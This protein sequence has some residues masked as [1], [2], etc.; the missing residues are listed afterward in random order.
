MAR[1]GSSSLTAY[2]PDDD[3]ELKEASTSKHSAQA[4]QDND[5]DDS[6]EGTRLLS[7]SADTTDRESLPRR[8]KRRRRMPRPM[9]DESLSTKA[10]SSAK[11][12]IAF[13]A[14]SALVFL[15]IPAFMPSSSHLYDGGKSGGGR[16]QDFSTGVM[17]NGTHDFK[18]TVIMISIDGLRCAHTI[19]VL[20]EA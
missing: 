16:K 4:E 15:V 14:A 17:S 3:L 6:R 19:S 10:R 9:P 7:S 20:F 1:D 2:S 8:V 13:V 5:Y 18:R 12:A 11:W